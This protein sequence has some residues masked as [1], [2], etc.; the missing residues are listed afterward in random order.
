V[1]SRRR[2]GNTP[3]I[4]RWASLH[5]VVSSVVNAFDNAINFGANLFPSKTATDAYDANACKVQA[6][7]EVPVKANKGTPIINTIPPANTMTI[8]GGTPASTGMKVALD[9]LKTLD[10][11]VPRAVLFITDGAA[12]CGEG[13]MGTRRCS[14]ST[15]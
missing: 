4:T 13:A 1:G 2:S 5:A 9:H 7:V 6:N 10:P 15:T 3:T 14:S 8:K 11:T 12:N